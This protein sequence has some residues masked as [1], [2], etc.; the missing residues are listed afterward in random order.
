MHN[1]MQQTYP[2]PNQTLVMNERRQS[3][4]SAALYSNR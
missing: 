1:H 2:K 3:N 4:P